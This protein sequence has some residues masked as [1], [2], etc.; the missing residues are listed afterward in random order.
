MTKE[1]KLI[2]VH[3]LS[4]LYSA[5]DSEGKSE[6]MENDH[7]DDTPNVRNPYFH[8]NDDD[9]SKGSSIAKEVSFSDSTSDIKV[10]QEHN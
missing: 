1:E 10:K 9:N 4:Y 7:D 5:R 3:F 2:Q 8:A 6:P